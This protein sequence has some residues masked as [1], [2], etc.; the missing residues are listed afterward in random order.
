MYIIINTFEEVLV[1]PWKN[2]KN[3]LLSGI[4]PISIAT[5][6]VMKKFGVINF[7]RVGW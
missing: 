6:G 2:Y 3:V 1:L 4:E 7:S 5:W